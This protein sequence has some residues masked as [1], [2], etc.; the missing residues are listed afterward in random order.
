MNS[1][2]RKGI[3][4]ELLIAHGPPPAIRALEG[5][6][7]ADPGVEVDALG[8]LQDGPGPGVLAVT[9]QAH[10]KGP[11]LRVIKR[12][13]RPPRSL[14]G[15]PRVHAPD[16]PPPR[17][18][19][20]HTALTPRDCLIFGV[21]GPDAPGHSVLGGRHRQAAQVSTSPTGRRRPMTSPDSPQPRS[22]P[23]RLTAHRSLERHDARLFDAQDEWSFTTEPRSLVLERPG[24]GPAPAAQESTHPRP[25]VPR[26]RRRLRPSD[27][28]LGRS[29]FGGAGER[30]PTM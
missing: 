11:E 27:A 3:T 15:E 12:R 10:I 7:E 5:I 24:T 1:S 19:P 26:R 22:G 21:S 18:A 28:S 13:P 16:R 17:R 20:R 30:Q 2:T 8:V 6:L 23:A 4:H 25:F 9:E 14:R 29:R